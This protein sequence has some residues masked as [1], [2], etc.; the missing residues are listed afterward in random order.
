[1][2]CEIG[3][4]AGPSGLGG[5]EC[6]LSHHV[7]VRNA[8]CAARGSGCSGDRPPQAC[9]GS[10]TSLGSSDGRRC[11]AKGS[12]PASHRCSSFVGPLL[13]SSRK[14]SETVLADLGHLSLSPSPRPSSP[15][16]AC[17]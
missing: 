9:W 6:A 10:K 7:Q 5:F 12:A 4:V 2:A 8:R 16:R 13:V 17:E 15:A 3:A 14:A 11:G 1:M